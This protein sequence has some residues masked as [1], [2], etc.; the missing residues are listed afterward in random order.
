[1]GLVAGTGAGGVIGCV[2]SDGRV[3]VSDVAGGLLL[4]NISPASSTAAIR[5]INA[6]SI[7][8]A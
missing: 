5:M 3:F 4:G 6:P 1:M 2:A 7:S 8:A